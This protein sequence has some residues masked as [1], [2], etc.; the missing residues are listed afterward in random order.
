MCGIAGVFH[1]KTGKPPSTDLLK[2]ANLVQAHRGPDAEGIW[3]HGSVGF[4]HRRLAIIDL[5]E[6]HQPMVRESW[7]PQGTF[8]QPLAICFNGEIYNYRPL[9]LELV[10]RGRK[11]QTHSDTEVIL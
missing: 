2:F 1:F 11:F 4:A 8:G 5:A 7:W 6:G 9:R 10:Q 3:V